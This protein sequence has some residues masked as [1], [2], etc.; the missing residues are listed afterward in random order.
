MTVST[1]RRSSSC[2]RRPAKAGDGTARG[3]VVVPM[4]R[5]NVVRPKKQAG[6]VKKTGDKW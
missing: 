6:D 2:V 4:R 5:Q 3:K 1:V